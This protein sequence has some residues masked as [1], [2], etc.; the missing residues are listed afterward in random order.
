MGK[1][2]IGKYIRLSQ[3]VRD[4][5]KRENKAESASISPPEGFDPEFHKW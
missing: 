2:V 4:L 5:M 1:W 3:A